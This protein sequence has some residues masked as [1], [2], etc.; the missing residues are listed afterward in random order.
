MTQP[1]QIGRLL[2][3]LKARGDHVAQGVDGEAAGPP[4]IP[5]TTMLHRLEENLGAT[6]VELTADDLRAIEGA[7]GA[8]QVRGARYSESSQRMIDR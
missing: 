3:S 4:P 5:G 8:I 7:A 2:G 1:L 6:E